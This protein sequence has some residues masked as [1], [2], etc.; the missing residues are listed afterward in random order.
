M[1]RRT[2]VA[3]ASAGL[4]AGLPR[5]ARTAD[6]PADRIFAAAKR[7]WLTRVEAPY[8]SFALRERYEWR[9]R[10]HD[11]W[12]TASYRDDDRAL[13]LRR[14]IVP[15]DEAQRLRGTAVAFD[16][17]LHHA[18]VRA[19]TLDTNA[20]ADAFP[21]LDPLIEP[22]ASFGLLRRERHAYLD[23]GGLASAGAAVPVAAPTPAPT[24][25]PSPSSAAP[26]LRELAHVEAFARDYTIALA[27][28]ESV[29]GIDTYHLTLVP[30]WNPR[31]NRL[32]DLLVDAN[33]FATLQLAVQGLFGGKPYEDARW[34]VTYVALAGRS[35]VQQVRT[36]ET[37]RFG[38]DRFV[39]GLQ[40]DFVGYAF[41]DAI[42]SIAFERLI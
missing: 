21:I 1:N 29:R 13:A 23:A 18:S 8:V 7:V 38:L 12:W 24:P 35:Y 31:V 14:S 11:N 37:L 10:T 19:D 30:T 3:L 27:G 6:L 25:D 40:F 26:V 15:E 32:R 36:E 2:F 41:P 39:N 5:A 34:T 28:I 20:S 16:L 17:H 22:N 4:G 42:P 9:G 33:T